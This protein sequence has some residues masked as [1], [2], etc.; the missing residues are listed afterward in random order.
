MTEFHTYAMLDLISD[1]ENIDGLVDD[2]HSLV[3]NDDNAVSIDITQNADATSYVL[4]P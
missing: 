1:I 2:I 3:D 4:S